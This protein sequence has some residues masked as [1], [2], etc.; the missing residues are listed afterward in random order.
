MAS[1]QYVGTRIPLSLVKEFEDHFPMQGAK[2]WFIRR[3]FERVVELAENG[4]L[5]PPREAIDY[6]VRSVAEEM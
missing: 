3:C 1:K 5:G 6:T 4:E 2:S